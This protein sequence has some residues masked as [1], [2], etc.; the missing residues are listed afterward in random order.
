MLVLSLTQTKIII[1]CMCLHNFIRDSKLFDD[2]FDRVE[3]APYIHEES[4][5][6]ITIGHAS[7]SS[8]AF[9]GALR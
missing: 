7:S 5:S 2:H 1:A 3:R 6:F 9:M 4:A 8:D